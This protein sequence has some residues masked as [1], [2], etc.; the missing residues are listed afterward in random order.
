MEGWVW[1]GGCLWGFGRGVWGTYCFGLVLRWAAV[2]AGFGGDGVLE[3]LVVVCVG[4]A[5]EP[6][7][8][9]G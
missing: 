1:E 4:E 2:L 7:W 6:W 9:L 5:E 3:W 8:W